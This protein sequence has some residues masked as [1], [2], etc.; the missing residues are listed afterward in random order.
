MCDPSVIPGQPQKPRRGVTR[1][2]TWQCDFKAQQ[3]TVGGNAAL[4]PLAQLTTC[5]KA[6][7]EVGRPVSLRS[8]SPHSHD[9]LG[10][11]TAARVALLRTAPRGA[12]IISCTVHTEA[13]AS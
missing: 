8:S 13:T 6:D 1:F 2:D 4:A 7:L 12:V 9:L 11:S 10:E 5:T 3:I